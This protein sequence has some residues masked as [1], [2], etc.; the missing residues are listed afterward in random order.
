LL[1]GG[2]QR[3]ADRR[4][5]RGPSGTL[6]RCAHRA[7]GRAC[8]QFGRRTRKVSTMAAIRSVTHTHTMDRAGACANTWSVFCRH[9]HLGCPSSTQ[10]ATVALLGHLQL[11][12]NIRVLNEDPLCFLPGAELTGPKIPCQQR[13]RKAANGVAMW[14]IIRHR[15]AP[16]DCPYASQRSCQSGGEEGGPGIVVLFV[17]L[18]VT[19]NQKCPHDC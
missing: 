11:G 12:D 3:R 18:S 7:Q 16:N 8:G 9:S 2:V 19:P 15:R 5:E 1:S 6:D 10:A 13:L 17:C 4:V 14:R